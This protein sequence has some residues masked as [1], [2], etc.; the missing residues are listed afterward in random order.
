[1]LHLFPRLSLFNQLWAILSVMLGLLVVAVARLTWLQ[2]VV[3]NI[4]HLITIVTLWWRLKN[5]I[6]QC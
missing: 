3:H 1:M 6:P 4:P 2:I 5:I